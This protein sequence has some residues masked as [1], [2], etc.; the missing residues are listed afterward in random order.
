MVER[1]LL[2]GGAG[3]HGSR[4]AAQFSVCRSART[5]PLDGIPY[6]LAER[7]GGTPVRLRALLSAHLRPGA[8]HGSSP[9][10]AGLGARRR[11]GARALH[12]GLVPLVDVGSVLLVYALAP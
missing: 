4:H 3:V 7:V 10:Y 1:R 11:T 2:V 12:P 8:T 9:V 5:Q 6:G